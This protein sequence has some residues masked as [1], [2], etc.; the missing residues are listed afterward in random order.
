MSHDDMFA[1]ARFATLAFD[2]GTSQGFR[3]SMLAVA[4]RRIAL[5]E[6]PRPLSAAPIYFGWEGKVA[7]PLAFV[8]SGEHRG[9]GDRR[10]NL[11]VAM[12]RVWIGLAA[13][14]LAGMIFMLGAQLGAMALR[15]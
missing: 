2:I 7:R 3:L 9:L 6:P 12:A 13:V 11:Q 14:G 15:R 4:K 10:L 8:L 1:L 5:T